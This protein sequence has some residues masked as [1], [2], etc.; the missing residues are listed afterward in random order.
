MIVYQIDIILEILM[1]KKE[2]SPILSVH[3]LTTCLK[4]GQDIWTVV[5]HLDFSL[6]PGQTLALVGESGCG[7]SMTALSLMR[8]LPQPPALP[9]T[10]E[11][12]YRERNLLTLPEKEMRRIR[13]AKIA[14]IFQDP[15]SALNPVY[16]VGNQLIEVAELH[17]G[18]FGRAAWTRAR[19]ALEAVGIPD[20]DKRLSAYP[21]QLSGG[22][23]QR[24]M[25]AMALMC[26]PDVLI[27]DEPTTAL[28]VTVQAQVLELIRSLQSQNG[29]ALLLITHDMGVVAEM[30]DEVIVMYVA[31]GIER[32]QIG[33]LFDH[34]AHPYTIG[35]F[36]S[37][38]SLKNRRGKLHPIPGQ[39]PTFRHI[40]SGCRFHPR[41][42]YVMEKCR[43]GPVPD[44]AIQHP[45]HVAK[46]W[47]YDGS[48]ESAMRWEHPD[49]QKMD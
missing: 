11:V 49:E 34:P 31:Q 15:M 47:L 33:D 27:A 39:V 38:P 7:K 12:L 22:L 1:S 16:T 23:K 2:N 41:C 35:L 5:D 21:H 26:E 42:P 14:M 45:T 4:I 20:A 40:P 46:C 29:M 17:L 6:Y 10:G 8:I 43:Q 13:G 18:L 48:Q 3:D 36:R 19:E 28:D 25:I 9:S 44:F 32:A 30:A 24:V 37:R